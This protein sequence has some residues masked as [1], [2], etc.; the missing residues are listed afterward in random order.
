MNALAFVGSN[1]APPRRFL[2][3]KEHGFVLMRFP[4]LSQ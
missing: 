3:A 1:P 4:M 2:I